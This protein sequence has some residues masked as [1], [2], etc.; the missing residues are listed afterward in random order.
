MKHTVVVVDTDDSTYDS[1]HEF[2]SQVEAIAFSDGMRAAWKISHGPANCWSPFVLSLD[3]ERLEWEE[4]GSPGH[5][6]F[7]VN[8]A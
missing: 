1:H 6:R 8:T 7:T 5:D 3:H 4:M 2:D